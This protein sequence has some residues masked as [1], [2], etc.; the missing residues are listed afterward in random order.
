MNVLSQDG[1]YIGAGT[2]DGDAKII[3]CGYVELECET[4]CHDLITKSVAFTSDSRHLA[5][6]SPDYS[7]NF[8]P[9]VKPQGLINM[10]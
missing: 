7:Y 10:I 3:N 5:S 8:L 6:A 1:L 4:K 2:V 9:N